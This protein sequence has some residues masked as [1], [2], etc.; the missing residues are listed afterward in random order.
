MLL[1]TKDAVEAGGHVDWL[2]LTVGFFS[3]G[4]VGLLAL[5]FFIPIVKQGKL[6]YFVVYLIPVGI[7][8]I[9]VL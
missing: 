3:A 9:C 2:S 1:K 5:R 6:H 4:I 8:G 7:L